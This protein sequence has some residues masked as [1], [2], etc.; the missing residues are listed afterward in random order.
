MIHEMN[1]I[2]ALKFTNKLDE[3]E[4]TEAQISWNRNN[5]DSLNIEEISGEITYYRHI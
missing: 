2:E 4:S 5:E 1:V 3:N